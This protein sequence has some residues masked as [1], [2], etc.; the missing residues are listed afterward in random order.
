[1]KIKERKNKQFL[2]DWLEKK[3]EKEKQ[4]GEM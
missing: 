4:P 1:M 3:W 2:Q